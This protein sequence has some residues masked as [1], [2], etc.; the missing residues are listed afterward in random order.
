MLI[1]LLT[2]AFLFNGLMWIVVMEFDF[3]IFLILKSSYFSVS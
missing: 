2:Y 3:I 1:V